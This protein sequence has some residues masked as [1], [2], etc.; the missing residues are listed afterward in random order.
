MSVGPQVRGHCQWFREESMVAWS[1]VTE[2]GTERCGWVLGEEVIG[3][4]D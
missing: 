3:L 1:Q 2:L 4:D